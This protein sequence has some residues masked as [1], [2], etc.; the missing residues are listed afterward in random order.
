MNEDKIFEKAVSAYRALMPYISDA[1]K[2]KFNSYTRQETH[3]KYRNYVRGFVDGA[4]V[5]SRSQKGFQKLTP[6][7]VKKKLAVIY[8]KSCRAQ[9]CDYKQGLSDLF[10]RLRHKEPER[11]IEAICD[12][13]AHL[14]SQSCLH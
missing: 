12:F 10:N 4:K 11:D 1:S 9:N 7:K 13:Y 2:I 6:E 5:F 8:T 14:D 3:K